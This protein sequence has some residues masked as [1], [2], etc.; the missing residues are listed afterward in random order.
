MS[1]YHKQN[2]P[3]LT[4]LDWYL[5]FFFVDLCK[6]DFLKQSLEAYVSFSSKVCSWKVGSADNDA[7]QL[8]HLAVC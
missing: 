4:S 2:E 1:A 6:I 8:S 7:A 5:G 3:K